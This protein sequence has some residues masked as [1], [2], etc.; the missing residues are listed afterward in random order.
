MNFI[1]QVD[2]SDAGETKKDAEEIKESTTK[3]KRRETEEN[4]KVPP[5]LTDQSLN[6]DDILKCDTIPGLL[7]VSIT[8]I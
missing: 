8:E 6:F 5:V 2:V 7:T 3:N 4:N 1:I